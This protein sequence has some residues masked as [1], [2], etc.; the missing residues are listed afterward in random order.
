MYSPGSFY[1]DIHFI[2]ITQR[3]RGW[4]NYES[5]YLA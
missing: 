3:Y 4:I 5:P 1:M 2:S